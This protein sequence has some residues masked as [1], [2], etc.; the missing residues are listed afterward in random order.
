M[1]SSDGCVTVSVEGIGPQ[2]IS[3][4]SCSL[5]ALYDVVDQQ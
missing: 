4:G 2:S 3:R 5:R 1:K